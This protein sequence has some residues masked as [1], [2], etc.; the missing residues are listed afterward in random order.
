MFGLPHPT[1]RVALA[2]RRGEDA[3][4]RSLATTGIDINHVSPHLASVL[5]WAI[6]QDRPTLDDDPD[7]ARAIELIVAAGAEVNYSF[8]S[9]VIL[10]PINAAAWHNSTAATIALIEAGADVS[11]IHYGKSPLDLAVDGYVPWDVI[12]PDARSLS[13]P[14]TA[15]AIAMAGGR[16]NAPMDLEEVRSRMLART[17]SFDNDGL[18]ANAMDRCYPN[19]IEWH[20]P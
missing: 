17:G 10:A 9:S 20:R 18:V 15:A 11:L 19:G 16:L 3:L 13:N 2:A 14:G 5:H 7:V 12:E 8:G 6:W 4:Q 1:E